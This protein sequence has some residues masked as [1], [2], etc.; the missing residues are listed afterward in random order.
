[1]SWS[2]NFSSSRPLYCSFEEEKHNEPNRVGLLRRLWFK[3][4]ETTRAATRP[5][6]FP[7]AT[8]DAHPPKQTKSRW[9]PW[10]NTNP[11]ANKNGR[12][13]NQ[14]QHYRTWIKYAKQWNSYRRIRI[15]GILQFR[16]SGPLSLSR[17]SLI[18]VVW[19]FTCDV[20]YCSSRDRSWFEA[21]GLL[22]TI[23]EGRNCVVNGV[24]VVAVLAGRRRK[25]GVWSGSLWKLVTT[26]IDARVE[27]W[28]RRWQNFNG[29]NGGWSMS[30]IDFFSRR[31]FVAS[32]RVYI[33]LS[34]G[35]WIHLCRFCISLPFWLSSFGTCMHF[36]HVLVLAWITWVGSCSFY[37]VLLLR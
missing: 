28:W 29:G 8:E 12:R 10:W 5:P 32:S 25:K 26:V 31:S 3:T 17:L 6:S 4:D 2:S 1:M 23:R 35:S 27:S 16:L 21:Q 36:M 13:F 18:L 9:I 30:S 19:D 15:L 11:L 14:A 33:E 37:C 7:T 22:R 24:G 20:T 34:I